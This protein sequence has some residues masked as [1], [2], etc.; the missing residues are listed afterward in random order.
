MKRPFKIIFSTGTLMNRLLRKYAIFMML[1]T[2][3]STGLIGVYSYIQTRNKVEMTLQEAIQST[4]R[5]LNDKRSSSRL[6][7]NQLTGSFD[8][9]EN[10]T[11]YLT[12]PIDE[13]FNYI[14]SHQSDSQDFFLLPDELR[15]VYA[16]YDDL[17]T[18]YISLTQFPE[19]L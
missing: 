8:R 19:Y 12:K 17:S 5:M 11:A 3:L 13:Y 7:L 14:Y 10:V 9:I 6:I 2:T 18:L 4:T 15:T 16:N 1:L